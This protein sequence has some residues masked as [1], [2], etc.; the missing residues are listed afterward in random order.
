MWTRASETK[1]VEQRINSG[2]RL[3]YGFLHV[4][5][6]FRDLG[7]LDTQMRKELEDKVEHV[8]YPCLVGARPTG[9]RL[10]KT[11]GSFLR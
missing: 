4:C 2:R 6:E 10:H 7:G 3:L 9:H 8:V 1:V 11:T 5:R